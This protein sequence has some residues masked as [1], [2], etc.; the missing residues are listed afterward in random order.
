[1]TTSAPCEK[2][3]KLR[4]LPLIP[5]GQVTRLSKQQRKRFDMSNSRNTVPKLPGWV[6]HVI[7]L[8]LP[9]FTGVMALWIYL[10]PDLSFVTNALYGGVAWVFKYA[11]LALTTAGCFVFASFSIYIFKRIL[12]GTGTLPSSR[13]TDIVCALVNGVCM[14][15][16]YGILTRNAETS[17]F[18]VFVENTYY[19]RFFLLVTLFVASV[20]LTFIF[21]EVKGAP[22]LEEDERK[23]FL[24]DLRDIAGYVAAGIVM[25]IFF[26]SVLSAMDH[27]RTFKEIREAMMVT[28]PQD[29]AFPMSRSFLEHKILET[30]ENTAGM[31]LRELKF[32]KQSL[33][34][35]DPLGPENI[36]RRS[37]TELEIEIPEVYLSYNC[38][39]NENGTVEVREHS[40]SQVNMFNLLLRSLSARACVMAFQQLDGSS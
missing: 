1:M 35:L 16:L 26:I 34:L 6:K 36:F 23:E 30:P 24:K 38:T 15:I 3:L 22:Q 12:N 9:L 31:N 13:G 29:P 17:L 33:A 10:K 11:D 8:L 4:K 27:T 39:L 18:N 19:A 21:I 7:C 14:Q 2:K 37:E 25:V 5:F 28:D 20:I 40:T 32:P